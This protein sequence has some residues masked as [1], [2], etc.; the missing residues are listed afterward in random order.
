MNLDYLFPS[1]PKVFYHG[2]CTEAGILDMLLPPDASGV[3]SEK[4]RNKNL[5]RIFFTE[6]IGLAKVYAGRAANS[7][8][9]D[10]VL[11]KV[12]APVDA[13]CMNDTPGAT[14]WHADWAFAEMM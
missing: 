3:L 14:V 11:F 9:G 4:G 2:S 13:V 10:P 6:D 5:G 7:I 12:I 1:E 8:G